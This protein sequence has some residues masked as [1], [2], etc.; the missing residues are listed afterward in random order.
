MHMIHVSLILPQHCLCR[1]RNWESSQPDNYGNIEACVEMSPSNSWEWNDAQC[2]NEFLS[3]C[4][5]ETQMPYGF[6]GGGHDCQGNDLSHY[7]VDIK[8]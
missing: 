4:E 2:S 1:Y 3:L 8:Q 7:T 5:Y 6:D